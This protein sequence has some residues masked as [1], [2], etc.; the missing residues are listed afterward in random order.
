MDR[1]PGQWIKLVCHASSMKHEISEELV[2]KKQ[3][4][5]WRLCLFFCNYLFHYKSREDIK[6][7]TLTFYNCDLKL[8][9]D[10]SSV[11]ELEMN[12]YRYAI[13]LIILYR[14]RNWCQHFYGVFVRY[15]AFNQ[16]YLSRLLVTISLLFLSFLDYDNTEED[17][18]LQ[19][20][21]Q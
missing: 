11:L 17:I 6:L 2:K 14:V 18:D 10:I 12:C 4:V 1:F 3:Y 8:Y 19:N 15:L 16:N 20:Q 13:I 21:P 9:F 5:Y 7:M